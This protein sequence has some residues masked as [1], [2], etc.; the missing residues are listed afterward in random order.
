M[1]SRSYALIQTTDMLHWILSLLWVF[2]V[3]MLKGGALRLKGMNHSQH[4]K[5]EL[6]LQEVKH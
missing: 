6:H 4:S 5:K 1:M 2:D 3:I